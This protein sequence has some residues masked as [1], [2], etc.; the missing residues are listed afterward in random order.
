MPVP[1]APCCWRRPVSESTATDTATPDRTVA[2]SGRRTLWGLIDQCLSSGS[3]F[4]AA[5]LVVRSSSLEHVG[6]W[7]LAYA[8]YLFSVGGFRAFAGRTYAIRFATADPERQRAGQSAVCGLAL[9]A[10]LG[11]TACCAAASFVLP[12]PLRTTTLVLG[13]LCPALLLQDAWRFTLVARGRATQAAL[14]DAIWITVEI[15]AFLLVFASGQR[16]AAWLFGAWSIGGAISGV[17]GVA[18]TGVLPSC[19]NALRFART[20]GD[21]SWPLLGEQILSQGANQLGVLALGA[22][23][24]LGAIGQLRAGQL[25]L[26]P[27]NLAQQATPLVALP[28]ARRRRGATRAFTGYVTGIAA[29]LGAVT[30]AVTIGWAAMPDR[31]GGAILHD[32]W[33]P[34]SSL[35]PP[36]AIRNVGGGLLIA[37]A[38]GFQALERAGSSLRF[39]AARGAISLAGVLAGATAFGLNGAVWA[40]ALADTTVGLVAFASFRRLTARGTSS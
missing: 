20:H 36:L 12:E 24:P 1:L 37:A 28:E 13:V 16:T 19:R 17:A 32:G 7:S 2:G 34:A 14:L 22:L 30:L 27:I 23:L 5:L 29:S 26:S 18:L 21:V 33:H 35:L 15:P 31:L 3:N 39:G 9:I 11:V 40:M 25:L 10:G 38:V 8:S 4:T 6:A